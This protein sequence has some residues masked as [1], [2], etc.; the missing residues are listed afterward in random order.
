[1]SQAAAA[2]GAGRPALSRGQMVLLFSALMISALGQTLIY[3][4]LPPVGRELG[5]SEMQIGLIITLSAAAAFAFAF[6]WGRLSDRLGRV[7]VI[8]AG[9]AGYG[10][11]TLA[12]VGTIEAGL[13]GVFSV[14]ATYALMVASRMVF[15]AVASSVGPSAQAY[16]ADVTTAAERTAGLAVMN[17]AYGIGMVLGPVMAGLLVFLDLLA[18]LYIAGVMALICAVAVHLR[19]AEPARHLA[20]PVA[21]GFSMFGLLWPYMLMACVLAVSMS[22]SQQVAPFYLQD[23]LQL[24]VRDTVARTGAALMALALAAIFVQTGLVRRYRWS[25]RVLLRA[26]LPLVAAGNLLILWVT[27]LPLFLAS[28]AL[29]GAGFGLAMP[30][31]TAA[32]SLLVPPDRQGR[33]AGLLTAGLLGGFVV[34]PVS[35]AALF[36]L[37][38]NLPYLVNGVL[39]VGLALF[40]LTLRVPSPRDAMDEPLAP[41]LG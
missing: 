22:I 32:A 19:L 29:L 8:V 10:V 13:A 38:A 27:D 5:L 9:L 14:P 35:G 33:M 31:Y 3:A 15:G 20:T 36:Q 40:V 12:F 37:H 23:L 25:P 17:A 11:F 18:P 6:V 4:I 26:G 28:F 24:D 1:V 30:G 2:L 39:A 16:V 41:P 34:G 7:W 21:P